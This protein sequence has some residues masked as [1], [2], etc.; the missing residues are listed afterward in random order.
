LDQYN[1]FPMLANLLKTL[2]AGSEAGNITLK[3]ETIIRTR[4]IRDFGMSLWGPVK[5]LLD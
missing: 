1:I 3:P 4:S 2:P 5:G